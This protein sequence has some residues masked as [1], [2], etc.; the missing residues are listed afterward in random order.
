MI[1]RKF[2][3]EMLPWSGNRTGRYLGCP[4]IIND[5]RYTVSGTIDYKGCIKEAHN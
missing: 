5:P 4:L 2:S 1:L 3:K